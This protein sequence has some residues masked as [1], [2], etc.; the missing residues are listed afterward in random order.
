MC[1]KANA[2]LSWSH[3]RTLL[4]V[5]D[6]AA[7]IDIERSIWASLE[8]AYFAKEGLREEMKI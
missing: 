1:G 3:Y 5:H 7:R 4:Q 2:C 6:E 8:H